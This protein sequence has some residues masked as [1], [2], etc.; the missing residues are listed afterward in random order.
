MSHQALIKRFADSLAA[1]GSVQPRHSTHCSRSA[2]GSTLPARTRPQE[3]ASYPLSTLQASSPGKLRESAAPAQ[4]QLRMQYLV[5]HQAR[6]TPRMPVQRATIK[7]ASQSRQWHDARHQRRS[8]CG[9]TRPPGG[10]KCRRRP[11]RASGCTAPP[12]G[13]TAPRFSTL[14]KSHTEARKPCSTGARWAHSQPTSQTT[15]GCKQGRNRNTHALQDWTPVAPPARQAPLRGESP[16]ISAAGLQPGPEQPWGSRATWAP[17]GGNC[18]ILSHFCAKATVASGNT[19]EKPAGMREYN[20]LRLKP[21][22]QG[23]V[24]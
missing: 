24:T 1:A 16:D 22:A 20:G 9:A 7:G 15:R 23:A 8:V 14:V 2:V 3:V 4:V 12:R 17:G 19:E 10:P 21:A 11:S 18:S 6:P 5:C 13:V